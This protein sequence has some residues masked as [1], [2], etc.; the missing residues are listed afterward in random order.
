VA[1]NAGIDVAL[2]YLD[3]IETACASLKDFPL[4][5]TPRDDLGPGLRT[6]SLE[7][8]ATIA[9]RVESDMVLILG[10]FHAGRLLAGPL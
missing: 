9:Y 4:R 5:G 7:G 1:A 2:A 10:V 3:R 6:I 8:R